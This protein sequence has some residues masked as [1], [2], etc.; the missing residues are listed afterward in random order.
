MCK[1]VQMRAVILL[2]MLCFSL[3]CLD[4][5]SLASFSTI[6]LSGIHVMITH[7]GLMHR[8]HCFTCIC[9]RV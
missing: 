7:I 5:V 9:A 4:P 1:D 8:I 6:I 2:I 3:F